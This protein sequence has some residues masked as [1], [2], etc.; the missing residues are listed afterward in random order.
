[1]DRARIDFGSLA[2]RRSGWFAPA[3]AFFVTAC[4]SA[5][6]LAYY[7][8]PGPPGLGEELPEPTDATRPVALTIG[9]TRFRIPANYIQLAS[10]RRGGALSEVSLAAMLPRLDG[11]SLGTAKDFA[12]HAPDSSVVTMQIRSGSP[13]LPEAQRLE[14]IYRL[15]L[16]DPQ[17]ESQGNGLMRYSFRQESGYRA[18]ELF[19]GMIDGQ[20]I[21]ILCD[22]V[23]ADTPAPNCLRDVPF[24]NGL[25]LSYR[26]KRP[27]LA[28][29]REIDTAVRG[30]LNGFIERNN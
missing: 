29:W 26:F 22:R 16:E 20:Q 19:T 8:A 17:G 21:V 15:Q 1:M 27:H 23:A 2:K 28:R 13:P 12:G 9:P 6:V 4:L 3:A 24:G 30:L 18:Q 7:F 25:G 14:R 10:A 11:Y 5:V